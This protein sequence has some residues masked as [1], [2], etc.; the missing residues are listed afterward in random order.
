MHHKWGFALTRRQWL[1]QKPIIDPYLEI[2]RQ[3]EYTKRDHARIKAYF[4]ELGYESPGTS[5]DAAKDVACLALG[6]AKLMCAVCYGKYIGAEG[7]H[8]RQELYDKLGFVKTELWPDPPV[9]FDF[10]SVENISEMVQ[11]QAKSFKVA[12]K[13]MRARFRTPQASLSM[14]FA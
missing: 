7:T 10:P 1:A 5:Q 14:L 11:A 4:R 9:A 13:A 6:V 3:R 12:E 8:F 2:V